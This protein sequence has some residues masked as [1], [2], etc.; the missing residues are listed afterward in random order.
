ME[1]VEVPRNLLD[2][3]AATYGQRPGDLTPETRCIRELR[4]LLA[5]TASD[6]RNESDTTK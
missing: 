2:A 1:T 6:K 4:A 3:I 5:E